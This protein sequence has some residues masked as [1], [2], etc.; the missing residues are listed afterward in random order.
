MKKI[1]VTICIVICLILGILFSFLLINGNKEGKNKDISKEDV[2]STYN[3]PYIPEG[4][5]T[6]ET[7]KASWEKD[8]NGNIIGYNNG[9]VIEDEIGNQFVWVPVEEKEIE[10]DI[11]DY[12]IKEELFETER[13]NKQI[14]KYGGFYI[15]RYEAGKIYTENAE[16]NDETNNVEG[17]PVSQKNAIPWNYIQLKYAKANAQKMY[18]N[19]AQVDSDLPTVLQYAYILQWLKNTGTD[20]NSTEN[21]NF[22][23]VSFEY[24]GYYQQGAKTYTYVENGVKPLNGALLSTG[25][26]EFTNLNNIYDLAG[27]VEEFADTYIEIINNG[28]DY[29]SGGYPCVGGNSSQHVEN[30]LLLAHFLGDKTPLP[31]IGFR[32]V[33]YNK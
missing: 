6:V 25:A 28:E 30:R 7:E 29:I 31:S 5:K 24:S 4:F 15:A 20:I 11:K 13:E 9:L 19:N 1:I 2:V 10:Q 16:Y 12:Y 33:L 27:N 17:I 3:N 22:T 21:G 26:S 32:V 14:S 8:E 23:D 18:E